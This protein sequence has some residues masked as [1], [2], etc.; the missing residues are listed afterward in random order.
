M[1]AGAGRSAYRSVLW[2]LLVASWLICVWR[3]WVALQNVPPPEQLAQP[4]MMRIPTPT[5][6]GVAVAKSGLELGVLLGLLLPWWRRYYHARLAAA[7]IGV[8]LWFVVS[9]PL[10]LSRMEWVHRRW[11][12]I[13][14]VTLLGIAAAVALRSL[15]LAIARARR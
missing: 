3:M 13:V 14:S 1:T 6:F 7:A 11:L 4:R 5:V 9:T 10:G 2:L 8:S 12:A 15:G